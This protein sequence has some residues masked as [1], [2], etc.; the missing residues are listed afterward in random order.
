MTGIGVL[1]SIM[2]C[3]LMPPHQRRQIIL[4]ARMLLSVW[5][6]PLLTVL[7]SVACVVAN[8]GPFSGLFTA[9]M[10]V[11]SATGATMSMSFE[12]I[13][14]YRHNKLVS[15]S[16][17]AA[18][19]E[20]NTAAVHP[21][22]EGHA[23]SIAKRMSGTRRKRS[24]WKTIL[25][26]FRINAST[27]L[28]YLVMFLYVFGI[29]R[30]FEVAR[31]IPGGGEAVVLLGLL[32][33]VTGNKLQLR[34]ISHSKAPLFV[35][36]TSVFG[37]ELVT[38]LLIRMMLLSIPDENTAVLL[39]LFNAATELMT[40]TWFFVDYIS[41]G[42][43]QR[44]DLGVWGDKK[45]KRRG[46]ARVVDGSNDMVVEYVTMALASAIVVLL[47]QIGAFDVPTVGVVDYEALARVLGVQVFTEMAIDTFATAL[48]AKGG[49]VPLHAEYLKGVTVANVAMQVVIVIIMVSFVLGCLVITH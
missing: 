35:M 33:K 34:L 23:A 1:F 31:S 5:A 36:D 27:F 9:G 44:A 47:S 45:F 30:A 4:F 22:E 6:V 37:Y 24:L 38:A 15:A 39:S 48:E 42:A 21:E 2:G 49:M 7:F 17:M 10:A 16:R 29:F 46:L 13:Y 8:R 12:S 26:I 25:H 3:K 43:K 14:R 19:I 40:R 20:Q 41:K 18:T 28:V 32:I 11:V